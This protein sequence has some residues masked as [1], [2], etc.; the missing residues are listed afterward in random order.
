M[1]KINCWEF[2]GCKREPDSDKVSELAVCPSATETRLNGVHGGKNAGRA[3]WAVAGTMCEGKRQGSFSEKYD[4]C[5]NC[6]FYKTVKKEEGENLE[7]SLV[8]LSKLIKKS[9][10][11]HTT[12]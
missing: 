3:C 2:K 11:S 7:M 9:I 1:N 6:D 8:L 10:S 4:N 12:H 5:M